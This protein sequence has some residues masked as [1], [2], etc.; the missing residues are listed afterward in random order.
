MCR[1]TG[2]AACATAAL[3]CAAQCLLHPAAPLLAAVQVPCGVEGVCFRLVSGLVGGPAAGVSGASGSG[4]RR[5]VQRE[6][7]APEDVLL[8][9]SR[10]QAKKA[11]RKAARSRQWEAVL[12]SAFVCMPWHGV[13]SYCWYQTTEPLSCPQRT[14]KGGAFGWLS[15]LLKVP[16]AGWSLL[17]VVS[18][19]HARQQSAAYQ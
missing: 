3:G 11:A 8:V 6:E 4:P 2:H 19:G 14:G 7:A 15:G 5:P 1:T 10:Q 16:R 13:K 17:V 9:P 12:G 18:Q